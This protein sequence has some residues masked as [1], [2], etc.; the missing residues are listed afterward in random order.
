M[1]IIDQE[2]WLPRHI[3]RFGRGNE[4]LLEPLMA[5]EVISPPILRGCN[6]EDESASPPDYFN[7]NSHCSIFTEPLREHR[8]AWE[9]KSRLDI[10]CPISTDD[11]DD[12]HELKLITLNLIFSFVRTRVEEFLT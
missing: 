7:C 12:S 4:T 10:A 3:T 9:Y 2:D 6:P 1:P 5:N 8:L 11:F